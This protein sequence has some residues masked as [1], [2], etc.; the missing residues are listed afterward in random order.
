MGREYNFYVYI[1]ANYNRR[2]I[3][4]GVTNNIVRRMIEHQNG[5]GSVFTERYNLNYL[6][7]YENWGDIGRAIFREKQI[8]AWSRV[9]K[10]D[11]IR[12]VN[13]RFL[14]LSAGLFEDF[15]LTALDIVGLFEELKRRHQIDSSRGARNDK[16]SL[17]KNSFINN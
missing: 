7:Y 2:V 10:I 13:P 9:K 17:I 12:S 14:D 5:I 4:V 16:K 3:Y 11:L 6:I 15:G 8:K 1:M